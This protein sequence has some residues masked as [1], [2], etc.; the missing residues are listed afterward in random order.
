MENQA[1]R[2][3]AQ[4]ATRALKMRGNQNR[5]IEG[6]SKPGGFVIRIDT[7]LTQMLIDAATAHGNP[8][9]SDDE[10]CGMVRAAIDRCYGQAA[11]E[12][13]ALEDFIL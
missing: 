8:V 9:P 12:C 4:S 3:R 11:Q 5:R 13:R 1:R 10:L 7:G 2:R 6:A